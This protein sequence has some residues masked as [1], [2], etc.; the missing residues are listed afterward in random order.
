[1]KT[2]KQD[3]KRR[4]NYKDCGPNQLGS[5]HERMKR[6]MQLVNDEELRKLIPHSL[7][8][9]LYDLEEEVSYHEPARPPYGRRQVKISDYRRL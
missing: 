3:L 6:V 2:T 1:M 8:D 7:Y 9:A 4:E 5:L